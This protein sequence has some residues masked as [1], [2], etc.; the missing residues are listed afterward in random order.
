MQVCRA[1]C[2]M[3]RPLTFHLVRTTNSAHPS[4][5]IILI[6]SLATIH[7]PTFHRAINP[8]ITQLSVKQ[9]FIPAMRRHIQ[10]TI[11]YPAPIPTIHRSIHPTIPRAPTPIT[12]R[13]IR[14]ALIPTIIWDTAMHQAIHSVCSI[15]RAFRAPCPPIPAMHTIPLHIRHLRTPFTALAIG[16][17]TRTKRAAGGH[18]KS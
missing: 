3:H 15:P 9:A 10:R 17:L 2:R 4:K 8:K 18:S 14:Q 5:P 12:Y 13:S 16:T 7:C 1:L 11:I 6:T